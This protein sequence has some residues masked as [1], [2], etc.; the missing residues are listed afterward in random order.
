[1]F[2]NRIITG[3]IKIAEEN[4]ENNLISSEELKSPEDKYTDEF[5][6]QIKNLGVIGIIDVNNFM[7]ESFPHIMLIPDGHI[8]YIDFIDNYDEI[9]DIVIDYI[10]NHENPMINALDISKE[11]NIPFVFVGTVFKDLER[12]NLIKLQRALGGLYITKITE[13]GADFFNDN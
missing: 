10:K 12:D 7:G 13:R 4:N 11:F 9:Y 8:S 2:R 3:L 6:E 1:M 5:I